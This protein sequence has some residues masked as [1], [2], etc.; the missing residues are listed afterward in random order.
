MFYNLPGSVKVFTQT[1]ASIHC[2]SLFHDTRSLEDVARLFGRSVNANWHHDAPV[3]LERGG[4]CH[5]GSRCPASPGPYHSRRCP[6]YF[7]PGLEHF[8]VF[9]RHDGSFST[10]GGG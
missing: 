3:S 4:Y 8:S 5:D 1:K 2:V 10:G 9:S 6:F 7:D